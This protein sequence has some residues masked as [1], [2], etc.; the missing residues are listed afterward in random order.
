[1]SAA[2]DPPSSDGGTGPVSGRS[3]PARSWHE[4]EPTARV[5]DPARSWHED[6]PAPPVTDP[7]RSWHEDDGGAASRPPA[8]DRS[9]ALPRALRDD[10][11]IVELWRGDA[12]SEAELA[13]VEETPAGGRWVLK[14]YSRARTLNPAI[15]DR[16]VNADREHV[17]GY[18][19]VHPY[20]YCDALETWWELLE[21]VRHGDL[22]AFARDHGGVITDH[23]VLR[24]ILAELTGA[25]HELERLNV[26]HRDLKP[27]NIFVRS[28]EQRIDLVLGD[29]GLAAVQDADEPTY[30]SV[31]GALMYQ[32]PEAGSGVRTPALDYWS[33]GMIMVELLT[34][35]HPFD[36][37]SAPVVDDLLRT[38][39]IDLS[40]ITDARWRRLAMGLLTRDRD[41][42]WGPAQLDD[43]LAGGDPE[44]AEERV[45]LPVHRAFVCGDR[46]S[47][48]PAEL[49]A[50]LL[51]DWDHAVALLGGDDELATERAELER[52]LAEVSD[53]PQ[54]ARLFET[55]MSG[56]RRAARL[57]AVTN[58]EQTPSLFGHDVDVAWLG[59]AAKRV[60]AGPGVGTE[61]ELLVGLRQEGI[62]REFA[63]LPGG[64]ELAIVDS[65]WTEEERRLRAAVADV[66]VD[67]PLEPHEHNLMV[68]VALAAATG[69]GIDARA[70]GRR[71][72]GW[73]RQQ[74][75]WFTGLDEELRA[76][77]RQRAREQADEEHARDVA[78][79][80]KE[81]ALR[82]QPFR[83]VNA[84]LGLLLGVLSASSIAL[85]RRGSLPT[86]FEGNALAEW[87]LEFA[88][89]AGL[90][91]TVT[92]VCGVLLLVS[93]A[94]LS[95]P[96]SAGESLAGV[97][98]ACAAAVLVPPLAP[99][100]VV[101]VFV[102]ASSGSDAAPPSP[103]QRFAALG[104]ALASVAAFTVVAHRHTAVVAEGMSA[105]P[106]GWLVDLANRWPEQLSIGQVGS[107]RYWAVAVVFVL[108][109]IGAL[110]LLASVR[111]RPDVP[112]GVVA[113][114]GVGGLA[115]GAAMLPPAIGLVLYPSTGPGWMWLV[116]VGGIV[117]LTMFGR[118]MPGESL[119]PFRWIISI[120][121][122]V[123]I[124]AAAFVGAGA[125]V[126]R[127][128]ELFT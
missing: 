18:H 117:V 23:E 4:D 53:N 111:F 74:P 9:G 15:L 81:R 87:Y 36:E 48:S 68:A 31:R 3:D 89:E 93:A 90:W 7:A 120:P 17:V 55:R 123:G 25:L 73:S 16:L 84:L 96:R 22:A 58:P 107:E 45:D 98:L 80:S 71:H 2:W 122:L 57:F 86:R 114:V 100:V 109:A 127:N 97:V 110:V 59:S 14:V 43:W 75:E 65:R 46:V 49:S 124:A 19:P 121:V 77:F 91:R 26:I 104:V 39:S 54:V 6:E 72:P 113:L 47:H 10:F 63:G 37:L 50:N 119:S 94:R 85:T 95:K 103:T 82:M 106:S 29:F 1:V 44:V 79:R 35:S 5:T 101:T 128:W 88:Q 24:Q 8:D 30:G 34:G 69:V 33:V 115:V 27:S 32:A 78:A 38:K 41:R 42:R 126:A 62:L 76:I 66:E 108:A 99:I 118:T 56:E 60:A 125:V 40:G 11:E 102:A 83:P 21:Y 116:V 70:T 12:G 105:P 61:A 52:W 67:G 28:V 51:Q 20:G 92:G 13:L 112:P 64:S